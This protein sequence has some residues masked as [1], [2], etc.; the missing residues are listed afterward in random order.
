MAEKVFVSFFS[1]RMIQNKDARKMQ[2]ITGQ[3]P[4]K[5]NDK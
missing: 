4:A 5:R 2:F 3:H 1:L